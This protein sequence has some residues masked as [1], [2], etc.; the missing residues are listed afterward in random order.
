MSEYAHVCVKVYTPKWLVAG[1][2][3]EGANSNGVR[4]AWV[5]SIISG[6]LRWLNTGQTHSLT[7]IV[8]YV[9]VIVE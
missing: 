3:E 7:H 2:W 9:V 6:L 4:Q 5:N 8:F 1:N